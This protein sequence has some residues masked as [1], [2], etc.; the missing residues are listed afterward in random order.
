MRRLI[1]LFAANYAANNLKSPEGGRSANYILIEKQFRH[2]MNLF[3][4]K[5]KLIVSLAISIM[6]TVIYAYFIYPYFIYLTL[7]PF[8]FL[9]IS[10]LI[11][12]KKLAL[13][14]NLL[15]LLPLIVLII[16]YRIP[17]SSD[18]EIES[19]VQYKLVDFSL[20]DFIR[21]GFEYKLGNSKVFLADTNLKIKRLYVSKDSYYKLHPESPWDMQKKN[22]TIKA[23]FKL[24]KVLNGDYS[25]SE[26]INY[27]IIN[28]K[29]AI[30][31]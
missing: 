18:F 23:R 15:P 11:K 25:N 12:N 8:I 22:Y 4:E 14:I 19:E 24:R 16:T 28:K 31:K 6:S 17:I 21:D 26:L 13:T 30:T 9:I 7:I 20:N 2:V 10:S 3:Q 27:E 5:R 29:P 1:S